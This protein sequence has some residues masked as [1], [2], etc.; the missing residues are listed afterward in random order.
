MDE[1]GTPAKP[2][3]EGSKYFV[4]GGIIV[5]EAKWHGLRDGLHGLKVRHGVRG[6]LK[7]RYFAPS[8]DDQRNPMKELAHD[9]RNAIRADVYK[10]IAT[11]GSLTTIAC[12]V[13]H[14]AAYEMLSITCQDD[15]YHLGYK[16]LTERFQYHL[17]GMSSSVGRKEFGIVVAD[18]RGSNDD[19][20]LR[21][22]HQKLLYAKSSTISS[23]DNLVEGLFLEP[24]HLSVGIQLADMV[25][26]AVWRKFERG[27]ATW[28]DALEPTLRRSPAGSID[29]WGIVRSPKGTWK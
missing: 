22:V 8:N 12:V 10:L 25:A 26:G 2:D 6:E 17:Q 19:R 1:S 18:H 9:A 23:Y 14:A 4:V 24:S 27:D 21:Q 28:F 15:V 13:S 16:G 29:G 7:W 20:L 11:S 5:P 3:A